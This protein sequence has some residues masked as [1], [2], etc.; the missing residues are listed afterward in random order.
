MA[1]IRAGHRNTRGPGGT[2]AVEGFLSAGADC[3][4]GPFTVRAA[5]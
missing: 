5:P 1:T 3:I 2:A 4:T